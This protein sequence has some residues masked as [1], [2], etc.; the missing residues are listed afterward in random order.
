MAEGRT[1]VCTNCSHSLQAWDEG[2][3]YYVDKRGKRRY[4]YHPSPERDRATG[5]EWPA[6]CLGCGLEITQDSAAAV[7]QCARCASQEIVDVWAVDGRVCPY[8]RAGTF[9]VEPDSFAI[10]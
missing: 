2:D 4:V 7:E 10:S 5:V 1:F 6:L 3:P 8:C 9:A